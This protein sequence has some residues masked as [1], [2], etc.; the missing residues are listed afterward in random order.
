[1]IIMTVNVG[2]IDQM[3]SNSFENGILD[4]IMSLIQ[5]LKCSMLKLTPAHIHTQTDSYS[6]WKN[7]TRY[8]YINVGVDDT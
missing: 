3:P 2:I 5:F 7:A 4:A 8:Y 6:Q 1:M